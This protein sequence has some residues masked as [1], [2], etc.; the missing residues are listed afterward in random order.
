MLATSQNPDE[1]VHAAGGPLI[2]AVGVKFPWV[3]TGAEASYPDVLRQ[4]P[5]SGE[6]AGVERGEIQARGA[7]CGQIEPRGHLR[8]NFIAARTDGGADGH[9]QVRGERAVTLPHGLQGGGPDPAGGAAPSRVH[10]G[11]GAV[12]RVGEQHGDA[13]GGLY[14]HHT[15]GGV[16][17]QGVTVTQVAGMAAGGHASGGMYLVKGGEGLAGS[18]ARRVPKPWVSHSKRSK[19][20]A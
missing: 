18:L 3:A 5:R 15:S 20:A 16:F 7:G 1:G 11:H 9:V 2:A 12:A 6:L 8:P 4:D 13:I 14:G 10:G 17:E 19:A